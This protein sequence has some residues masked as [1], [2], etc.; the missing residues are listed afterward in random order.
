[1]HKTIRAAIELSNCDPLNRHKL[2]EKVHYLLQNSEKSAT[3]H[4][5]L[6]AKREVRN[7]EDIIPLINFCI[8]KD[9]LQTC[10]KENLIKCKNSLIIIEKFKRAFL[11]PHEL[12]YMSRNNF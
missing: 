1:M 2:F 7:F 10:E 4:I 9:G 11:Q 3:Y 8:K 6:S 12:E 5:E